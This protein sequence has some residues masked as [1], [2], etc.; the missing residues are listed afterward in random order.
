MSHADAFPDSA[1]LMTVTRMFCGI[2]RR[3]FP[4]L[5]KSVLLGLSLL[6]SHV[7]VST[8]PVQAG[9]LEGRVHYLGFQPAPQVRKV[10]KDQAHCGTEV[11]IQTVQLHD[12]HGALSSA[13]VS[14]EGMDEEFEI[15]HSEGLVLNM[16]CAFFPRIGTARKDQDVEVRNQ[17][18]ILHN[19][20]IKYGKRT[21]LN[22]AQVPGGKPIV[23]GVKRSGLYVIRCDKHVFMEAY[24]HVFSHPFYA[25]TDQTGTFRIVNIPPGNQTILVWHETLGVLKKVVEIPPTGTVLVDFA[26]P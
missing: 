19:T 7:F 4:L 16:R 17:D 12:A 2:V 8:L 25:M 21:F 26:Y 23:K 9:T 20:H 24:L 14:V 6:G 1:D 22:V 10:T 5:L 3:V 13:V 15:D 11:S 18:P